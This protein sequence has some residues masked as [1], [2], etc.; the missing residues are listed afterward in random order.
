M[1]FFVNV[2][3]LHIRIRRT[4]MLFQTEVQRKA[5]Q[6]QP[7]VACAEPQ[8]TVLRFKMSIAVRTGVWDGSDGAA[9]RCVVLCV[10]FGSERAVV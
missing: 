2:G 7:L 3:S 9:L 6:A 4:E 8:T 1:L 5:A 10:W